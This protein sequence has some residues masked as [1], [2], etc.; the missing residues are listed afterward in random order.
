[1]SVN[2]YKAIKTEV[3]GVLFDSQ[4]EAKR[5]ADLKLLVRAG[6]IKDLQLQPAFEITINGR[7][8][9]NYRADFSYSALDGKITVEDSKGV[10]TPLYKLKKKLVEAAYGIRIIE[11]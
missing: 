4:R 5:Y 1:M 10:R 3:D 6:T 11:V 7:H 8:I 2:K 9:C